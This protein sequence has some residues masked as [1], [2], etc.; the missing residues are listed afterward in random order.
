MKFRNF[1]LIIGGQIPSMEDLQ[2]ININGLS[3]IKDYGNDWYEINKSFIE[4]RFL[5]LYCEYENATIYNE[6]VLNGEKDQKQK[7]PR[8]KLQVELKKQL[9]ACYDSKTHLFYIN[10]I[11]KRGFLSHYI[12]DTLQKEAVIKNI[13]TSLE[14]FQ[15]SVMSIK[16]LKFVQE[17]N[18]QNSTAD[19]MFQQQA[20][21]LGLD[22]PEK[23]IMQ[24]DYGHTP[25]GEVKNALQKFKTLRDAGNF[26]RILVVG[27][28]DK[29]VEQS[30]DFSSLIKAIEMTSPKN[31]NGRYNVDDI[32]RE[33]LNKIR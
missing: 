13:Y 10:N 1:Q 26:E 8:G 30:F 7:N 28:D 5:W 2:N 6:N 32:S 31:G 29:E 3:Y 21:L 9:F 17:R 14:E 15:N 12:S 33:F 23:I 22:M 20:N 24:V 27:V 25:I 18:L 19:S 4:D 11:D 16:Q